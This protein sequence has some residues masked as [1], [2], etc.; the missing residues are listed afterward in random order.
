MTP[1]YQAA[2]EA[3]RELCEFFLESRQPRPIRLLE[4]CLTVI[5]YYLKKRRRDDLRATDE[6]RID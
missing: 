3:T 1:E 2:Q 5:D 4:D 6:Y